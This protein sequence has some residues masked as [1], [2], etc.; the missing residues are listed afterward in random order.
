[1]TMQ[2][3][4]AEVKTKRKSLHWM[5]SRVRTPATRAYWWSSI[6]SVRVVCVE[7][8]RNEYGAAPTKLYLILMR[9]LDITMG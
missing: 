9:Q 1:M 4:D 6:Y 2:S 8:G 5:R 7:L 3:R